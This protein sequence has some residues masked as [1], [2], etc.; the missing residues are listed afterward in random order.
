MT[1]AQVLSPVTGE[2]HRRGSMSAGS[3]DGDGLQDSG[4]WSGS[5]E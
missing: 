4:Y 5:G 3:H 1:Q 2:W